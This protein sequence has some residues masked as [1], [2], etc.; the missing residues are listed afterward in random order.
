M[1]CA[2]EPLIEPIYGSLVRRY[3]NLATSLFLTRAL[4]PFPSSALRR[5][6]HCLIVRGW[7]SRV[8]SKG[9]QES[10][11][12]NLFLCIYTR[13]ITVWRQKQTQIGGNRSCKGKACSFFSNWTRIHHRIKVVEENEVTRQLLI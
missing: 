11:I 6:H 1:T 10:F 5:V 8:L 12:S 13:T 3:G 9:N 2:I 4:T 7:W